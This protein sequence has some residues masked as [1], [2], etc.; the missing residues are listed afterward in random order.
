MMLKNTCR[1]EN[2]ICIVGASAYG[3]HH[4][5]HRV[6]LN[7]TLKLIHV[8]ITYAKS[9]LEKLIIVVHLFSLLWYRTLHERC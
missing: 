2:Q 3:I 4:N 9:N 6:T 5:A 7:S 8:T 1:T